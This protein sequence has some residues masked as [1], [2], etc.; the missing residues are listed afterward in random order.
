MHLF[1]PEDHFAPYESPKF[2][3][4]RENKVFYYDTCVVDAFPNVINKYEYHKKKCT[5]GAWSF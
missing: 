1:L 5:D 3:I 4:Q 2:V